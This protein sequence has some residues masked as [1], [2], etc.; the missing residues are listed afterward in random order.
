[1]T[2]TYVTKVI[3]RDKRNPPLQ[4][5]WSAVVDVSPRWEVNSQPSYEE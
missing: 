1:M 3:E 2:V 4:E 5:S